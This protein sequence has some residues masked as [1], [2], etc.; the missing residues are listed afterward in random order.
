[1]NVMIAGV[2]ELLAGGYE[3]VVHQSLN[4][5]LMGDFF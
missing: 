1:M 4:G 3:A 5:A 2:T